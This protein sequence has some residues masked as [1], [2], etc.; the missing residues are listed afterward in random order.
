MKDPLS[1][2]CLAAIIAMTIMVVLGN[3]C[4]PDRT[5]IKYMG[6]KAYVVIEEEQYNR[7]VKAMEETAQNTKRMTELLEA[8]SK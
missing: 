3:G 4:E 2:V 8:K 1:L 7:L 5:A 6:R